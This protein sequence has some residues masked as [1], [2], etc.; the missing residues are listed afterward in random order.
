MSACLFSAK[1]HEFSSLLC[2][3]VGLADMMAQ[4]GEEDDLMAD[5]VFA[6]VKGQSITRGA[7]L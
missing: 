3:L 5:E 1:D 2:F 7:F 6:T 4:M